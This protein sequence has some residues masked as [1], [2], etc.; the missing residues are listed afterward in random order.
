MRLGIIGTGFIIKEFLPKLVKMEGIDV[1]AIQG[2]PD[3]MTEVETLCKENGISNGVATFDELLKCDIDTVYIAV[4][5]FIHFM[6]CKQAL[7]NG[8]N[9]ICEKPLCSNYKEAKILVD[10]AK[11]KQLFLFEAI[12]TIHLPNYQKIREWIPRIGELKIIQSQ[13][14]QYSR[15]YDAFRNG[16]ILPAFDPAKSGGALMDLNLYNLYYVVGLFGLPVSS[17]YYANIE[18]GIDTSGTVVLRYR[19][20][21]AVCTAAKDCKGESGSIIQGTKGYIKSASSPNLV[22]KAVLRLNDGTEEDFDDGSAMQRLIP[23]FTAFMNAIN[24]HDY[25]F[26]EDCMEKSLNVS[27]VQTDVRLKA[28]I[29]FPADEE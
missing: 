25:A 15:R 13:Y 29:V 18:R 22:G 17:E 24:R 1:T 14:S 28:G 2:T 9:V 6:Y 23:E 7:E 10:L 8:L 3:S 19:D 20:F 5:N 12:T 26:C 16:E 4:P 11:E 27:R 21:I